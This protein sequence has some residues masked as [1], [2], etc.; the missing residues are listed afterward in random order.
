[1]PNTPEA[2]DSSIENHS[3][4]LMVLL[5]A[6]K[7][8]VLH[9]AG[10]LLQSDTIADETDRQILKEGMAFIETPTTTLREI[11]DITANIGMVMGGYDMQGADIPPAIDAMHAYLLALQCIN[12][13]EFIETESG[14]DPADGAA[15][16]SA[17]VQIMDWASIL[18]KGYND[19]DM[20]KAAKELE[21]ELK[22]L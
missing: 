15:I 9:T 13:F 11:M 2:H 14:K 1:M 6:R 8:Q 12:R 3:G 7:G 16:K 19:P 20:L 22:A 17:M 21:E 18:A 5:E 4:D 10:E